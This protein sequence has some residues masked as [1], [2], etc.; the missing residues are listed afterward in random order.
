M[1][2][3]DRGL[4]GGWLA[5]CGTLLLLAAGGC[6]E[7][8]PLPPLAPPPPVV[9]DIT[10]GAPPGPITDVVRGRIG[11]IKHCFEGGLRRNHALSGKVVLHWLIAPT[12]LPYDIQFVSSTLPDEEVNLCIARHIAFWEFP[13]PQ[14][15]GTAEVSFPFVF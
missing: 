6:A 12:G 10:E 8:P 7:T 3:D 9:G 5:V 2:R 4:S 15:G 13:P 1:P 14:G 11:Q